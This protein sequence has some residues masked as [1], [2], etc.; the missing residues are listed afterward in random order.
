MPHR[1]LIVS[2]NQLRSLKE[3][4]LREDIL[5]PLLEKLD[6]RDIAHTHGPR[7]LGKDITCWKPDELGSPH[8]VAIVAKAGKITGKVSKEA[9]DQVTQALNSK[10]TIGPKGEIRQADTI[11]LVTNGDIPLSSEEQIRTRLREDENQR[12]RIIDGQKLWELWCEHFPV[13]L[14]QA[15]A[16]VQRQLPLLEDPA[17]ATR[18]IVEPG[19][20]ALEVKVTNADLLTDRHT[21]GS[22]KFAFPDTPEGQSKAQELARFWEVGGSIQLPGNFIEVRLPEV[23]R[24]LIGGEIAIGGDER[25]IVTISNVEDSRRF[26]VRIEFRCD[27]GDR[28]ALDYVDW[29]IVQ[30]G[31]AQVTFSNDEQS[32]PI[33]FSFVMPT[34][35]SKVTYSTEIVDGPVTAWWLRKWF[36][37][38]NCLSK[39]GTIDVTSISTGHRI[40]TVR[41]V[42][43]PDFAIDDQD[44]AQVMD[45]VRVQEIIN[46]PIYVPDGEFSS[47]EVRVRNKLRFLLE[48]Q[49]PESTWIE[50]EVIATTVG[51][52]EVTR[53]L[54]AGE[55][56]ALVV[57][58]EDIETFGGH[59]ISLGT[60]EITYESAKLLDPDAALRALTEVGGEGEDVTLQFVPGENNRVRYKYLKWIHEQDD[61][62]RR[63]ANVQR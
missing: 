7:E 24:E 19:R 46:R 23:L 49:E 53:Q 10:Y 37:I 50:I 6:Y 48:N 20:Q 57:E 26:P 28:A 51:A 8:N 42:D 55:S 59:R 56:T 61:W 22:T 12:L 60:V 47:E 43:Q 4:K 21:E 38:Q 35:Q 14:H 25:S 9:G 32:I 41:H 27:D 58:R 40:I 3:R 62:E 1:P 31:T 16:E 52:N 33:R 34:S 11:W 36:D 29:R 44:Y 45:L 17:I 39:Q 15:L 5:L 18:A 63:P 13:G 30:A 54:L 2:I